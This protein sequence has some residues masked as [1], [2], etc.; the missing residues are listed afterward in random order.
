M[1]TTSKPSLIQSAHAIEGRL[2]GLDPFIFGAYHQD[3]Y[4]KGNGK[5]GPD[6]AL[7]KGRDIGMDFGRQDGWSMYHGDDVPGFP[8]HPH[9]GFE[10]VTIVRKGLVDHADSLGATARYGEG[11][12]QWLTTGAGVQHGEMFPMVHEDKGNTLDLFQLWLNLPAKSK[13]APPDFTMFWAH[14]IPHVVQ[15]DAQGRRSE[16]EV[17]AGDYVPVD[18]AAAG[19]SVATKALR[20]PSDSWASEPGADV[21]IWIVRLE[22]GA[23]LTLPAA[24]AGINRAVYLT[25]GKTVTVDGH[26]FDQRVMLVLRSDL[27]VPMRNEGDEVI[28]VLLLQGKPI[29]EPVAARGPFVMNSEQELVQAMRDYQRTQFGGWPWPSHAHTHGKEKRFARHPDGRVETPRE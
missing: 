4:P 18:A 12:V 2:P 28:E 22:P 10:T 6:P 8:A 27:P 5:L 15:T 29:G 21:A 25:S 7:L 23:S 17:I 26:R 20:P 9:R 1:T 19:G 14:D 11:D 3:L 16:V 24:S 13:M